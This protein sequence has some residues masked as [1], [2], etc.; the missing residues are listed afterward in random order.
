MVI[1]LTGG[2][3]SGKSTVAAL[4]EARGA[5]VIDTDEVAREVA[6]PGSPVL[7]AIHYEFGEGVIAPDGSLK[8]AEL[9]RIVFSDPRRRERLNELTHPA[10]VERTLELVAHQPAEAKVVVVVPLLFESGFDKRCDVTIAIVAD[11]ALRRTRVATR[12]KVSEEHVAARMNA[13][14]ADEE[15]ERRADHVIRN[16]GALEDL[17]RAVDAVWRTLGST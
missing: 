9:A 5:R 3:G 8:R 16:D 10:I 1:G 12:D 11:P 14:L 15:Y 7:A 13:Q 4:L 17:E 2:I 6:M